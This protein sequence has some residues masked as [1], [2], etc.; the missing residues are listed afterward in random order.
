[1]FIVICLR[2]VGLVFGLYWFVLAATCAFVGLLICCYC[3]LIVGF[4][5]LLFLVVVCGIVV[6][7]FVVTFC[8]AY[9]LGVDAEMVWFGLLVSVVW[10]D[11]V[12]CRVQFSVVDVVMRIGDLDVDLLLGVCVGLPR[13]LG[14]LGCCGLGAVCCDLF[15]G[16][17]CGLV[18]GF[19]G[20][21]CWCAF[22]CVLVALL[23]VEG[24]FDW[25]LC[26]GCRFGI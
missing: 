1:M 17:I 13:G 6:V 26:W 9:V 3:C 12:C 16:V 11:V 23:F 15:G 24:L 10:F 7:W 21:G 19:G 8:V 5:V 18:F 25:F 4:G 20:W 14:C 2:W 22:D